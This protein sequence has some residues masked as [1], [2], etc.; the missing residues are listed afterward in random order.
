MK[1]ILAVALRMIS[2]GYGI[3]VVIFMVAVSVRFGGPMTGLITATGA[4]AVAILLII[5][6]GF[7]ILLL[8]NDS[9]ASKQ[10][11]PDI[12]Q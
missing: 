12:D 11:R 2:T 7:A 8:G 5:V 3:A 10:E 6:G 4:K 1:Q 9:I